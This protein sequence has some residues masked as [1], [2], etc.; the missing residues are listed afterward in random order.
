MNSSLLTLAWLSP[1]YCRHLGSE[2]VVG[3]SL[4][5]CLS[6]CLSNKVKINTHIQFFRGVY[7][8]DRR[9]VPSD[10]WVCLVQL[11]RKLACTDHVHFNQSPQQPARDVK[12]EFQTQEC[13]LDI[14]TG[15]GTTE[16]PYPAAR[17]V[18]CTKPNSYQQIGGSCNGGLRPGMRPW[19]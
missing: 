13:T 14:S 8:K 12:Q 2:P 10:L 6:L 18:P 4:S 3:S 11:V 1:D 5:I 9:G 16:E 7:Q 15:C 17:V 19:A